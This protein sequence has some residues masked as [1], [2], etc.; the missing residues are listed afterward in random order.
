M[1]RRAL[2]FAAL[3]LLAAPAAEAGEAWIAWADWHIYYA[4]GTST[5]Q[6]GVQHAESSAAWCQAWVQT[7]LRDGVSSESWGVFV[8]KGS[9]VEAKT[10]D[11][12]RAIVFPICLPAG[13]DP[14]PREAAR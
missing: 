11:G 3:L 7:T 1:I 6:W 5:R 10:R 14:R 12:H 9:H 13:V 2:A 8:P 4:D